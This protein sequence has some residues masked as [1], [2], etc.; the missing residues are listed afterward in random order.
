MR[1]PSSAS[2]T[3]RILRDAPYRPHDQIFTEVTWH[4]RYNPMRGVRTTRYA[5]VR[6][7]IEAPLVSMPSDILAGRYSPPFGVADD[8]IEPVCRDDGECP[9]YEIV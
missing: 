1:P 8:L 9:R 5:Y 4:D 3:T 6:S 2:S 7:F